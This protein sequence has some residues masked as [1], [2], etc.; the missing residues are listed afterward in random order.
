MGVTPSF[1]T[2]LIWIIEASHNV[3]LLLAEFPYIWQG[4]LVLTMRPVIAGFLLYLWSHCAVFILNR[5]YLLWVI[6]LFWAE[7]TTVKPVV[8]SAYSTWSMRF[9]LF[10]IC[11]GYIVFYMWMCFSSLWRFGNQQIIT[12]TEECICIYENDG[13]QK[14]PM[15]N[16]TPPCKI[17]RPINFHPTACEMK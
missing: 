2:S 7:C 3:E 14:L 1:I 6:V 5:H 15:C 13:A 9:C 8:I 11:V 17:K 4:K 10:H 12:H 16:E